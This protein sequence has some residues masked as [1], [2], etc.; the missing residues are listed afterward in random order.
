MESRNDKVPVQELE[1]EQ[2]KKAIGGENNNRFDHQ[3][4]VCSKCG[5]VLDNQDAFEIH[6]REKHSEQPIHLRF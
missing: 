6:L 2:L 1:P 5:A 3:R 4:V